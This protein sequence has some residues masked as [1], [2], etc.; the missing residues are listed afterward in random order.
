MKILKV[1]YIDK[2]KIKLTYED[3]SS[4]LIDL[5]DTIKTFVSKYDKFHELLNINYFRNVQLNK[6]WNTIQWEN[7]FDICPDQ[8]QPTYTTFN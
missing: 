1:K 3:N 4:I 7:G 5:E 8:L 6:E 2:Y